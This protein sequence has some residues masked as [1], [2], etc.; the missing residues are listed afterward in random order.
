MSELVCEALAT[1]A[2]LQEL[3][4]QI[5]NL[6][7]QPE[8][9]GEPVKDVLQLGTLAGT[10]VSAGLVTN[11][12]FVLD[13]KN[14]VKIF[15]QNGHGS[16]KSLVNAGKTLTQVNQKATVAT[17]AAKGISGAANA[18]LTI[19]TAILQAYVNVK[20]Q[21]LNGLI[22]QNLHRD[23]IYRDQDF[24]N[25]INIL[26][27]QKEDIAS[28]NAEIDDLLVGLADA[29]RSIDDLNNEVLRNQADNEEL[30]NRINDQDEFIGEA[31]NTYDELKLDFQDYRQSAIAEFTELETAYDDL[32]IQLEES[33]SNSDYLKTVIDQIA[34]QNTGYQA[35]ITE[36]R[37]RYQRR[38]L[39]A[40]VQLA[41]LLNL[42][43]S[44]DV[45]FADIDTN[46]ESIED[47]FESLESKLIADSKTT[48]ARGGGGS[49]VASRQAIANQQN[50]VLQFMNALAPNPLTNLPTIEEWQAITFDNPFTDLFSQLL[51]Q[52]TPNTTGTE[53]GVTEVELNEFGNNLADR[54]NTDFNETLI[55]LGLAGLAPTVTNLNNTLDDR[56]INATETA[57]CRNTQPGGCTTNNV[58]NP[59]RAGQ[60]ALNNKLDAI[61]AAL[62]ASNV[63]LNSSILTS[64][65]NLT[66]FVRGAWSSTVIDKTLNAANFALSLHNAV[67]LS[68]NIAETVLDTVSVIL[69]TIGVSDAEGNPID[70]SEFLINVL[71]TITIDLISAENFTELQLKLQAAN[72]IYQA[73]MNI[74][75]NVTDLMDTVMDLDEYTGENVAKIGNALRESGVVN[76]NAYSEM[77][78]DLD[79]RSRSK[80]LRR[81][82]NIEE[83]TDNVYSIA[84]SIRDIKEI[85]QDLQDSRQ[86]LEDSITEAET[87]LSEAEIELDEE[88]ESLPTPTETDEARG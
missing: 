24:N 4:D 25:I 18:A 78:E 37:D 12:D 29:N 34:E 26:S 59:L 72:R 20:Q 83:V 53:E 41:E 60:S 6:L 87:I 52:I 39:L 68:T 50:S 54:I 84:D 27:R 56:I 57:V 44:Y 74:L 51:P 64:L 88:I 36:L 82:D 30:Q 16:K 1:K 43:A 5:N 85:G 17:K 76:L 77:I 21:E 63:G 8:S 48:I 31:L 75:D 42:K 3:R 45:N 66:N 46:F 79:A 32:A 14:Q 86:E 33:L 2:E 40:S 35:Q 15:L 70:V 69:D 61:N 11:L 7:G 55:A 65:T 73:G 81:L 47:R 9:E 19:G 49:S 13:K 22:L 71:R 10:A 80:W 23:Q 62:G 58:T 67:M 28:A 38:E